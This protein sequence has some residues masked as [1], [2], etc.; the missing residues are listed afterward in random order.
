MVNRT[1]TFQLCGWEHNVVCTALNSNLC[2]EFILGGENPSFLLKPGSKGE[3]DM[4]HRVHMWYIF[5]AAFAPASF[6][7]APM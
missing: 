1:G 7:R 3:S 4:V 6:S 2:I 5:E